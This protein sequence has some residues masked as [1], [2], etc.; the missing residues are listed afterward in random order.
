M[1]FS[2]GIEQGDTVYWWRSID[3]VMRDM[4]AEAVAAEFTKISLTMFVED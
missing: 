4:F 3:R 2:M 1:F